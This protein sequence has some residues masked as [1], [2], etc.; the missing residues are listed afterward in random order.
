[1]AAALAALPG[2]LAGPAQGAGARPST[3]RRSRRWWCPI[4]KRSPRTPAPIGPDPRPFAAGLGFAAGIQFAGTGASA[5]ELRTPAGSR[6]SARADSRGR[7]SQRRAAKCKPRADAREENPQRAV[8]D[9]AG[10]RHPKKS[11][12]QPPSTSSADA[13][14]TPLRGFDSDGDRSQLVAAGL[15]LLALVL[16]S[17]AFLGYVSPLVRERQPQRR[18]NRRL[19]P[20]DQQQDRPDDADDGD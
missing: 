13:A 5:A 14:L 17:G 19:R 9:P 12:E 2:L 10:I 4:R 11:R 16:L 8:L 15:A 20:G 7:D 6:T 3:P 18:W 1:M